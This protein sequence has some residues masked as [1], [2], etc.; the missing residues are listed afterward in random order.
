M[1]PFGPQMP[2]VPVAGADKSTPP[3]RFLGGEDL[4]MAPTRLFQATVH[5]CTVHQ[6]SH[7]WHQS[8]RTNILQH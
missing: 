7:P 6:R 5:M 3:E 4:S 1:L 8:R 2:S